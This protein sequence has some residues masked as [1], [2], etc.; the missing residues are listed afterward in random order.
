MAAM[1]HS[2]FTE[3]AIECSAFSVDTAATNHVTLQEGVS[4]N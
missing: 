1:S 3:D 4:L 2:H